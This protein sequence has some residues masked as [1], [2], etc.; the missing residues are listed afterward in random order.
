M[1]TKSRYLTILLACG[2]IALAVS[3]GI[4]QKEGKRIQR[5]E[6]ARQ[7]E[8]LMAKYAYLH[9]A[10]RHEEVAA[11]FA[12]KTP[13]VRMEL[14]PL[15]RWDGTEGIKTAMIKFHRFLG[16]GN[17]GNL[18]V[19]PQTTPVIEVAGDGRTAKGVWISP[20]LETWK[21]AETGE[22]LAI[23]VWG[24]Y[25][26]DFVK[27]DGKWKFWHFHVYAFMSTPYDK[28]WVEPNDL[29]QQ[30]LLPDEIK[31]DVPNDYYHMYSTTSEIQY[32]P[33]PP[34]PYETFDEKTAY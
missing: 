11:L 3:W 24:H 30:L 7:V 34:E 25:G 18:M 1:E 12:T 19:H 17:P 14:S 10:G 5:V 8:N 16:V 21:N 26:I 31:P 2:L 33:V 13:G 15:G 6:D 23:W 28:S 20:G 4:V 32:L 9:T 29:Q 27:E 22:F